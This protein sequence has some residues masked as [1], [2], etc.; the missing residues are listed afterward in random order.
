MNAEVIESKVETLELIEKPIRAKFELDENVI[1]AMNQRVDSLV[2]ADKQSR[3]LAW[4]ERQAFRK[5]RL[6]V[7]KRQEELTEDAKAQIKQVKEVATVLLGLL[8]PGE[9]AIVGKIAAYDAKVES[10][11]KAAEAARIAEVERR[12][13]SFGDLEYS[14][15]PYKVERMSDAEFCDELEKASV[16]FRDVLAA[17]VEA[18]AKAEADRL[19]A[20]EDEA[21]RA[22]AMRIEREQLAAERK[23]LEAEKAER[24][25]ANRIAA[26]AMNKEREA[27]KAERDRIAKAD[28]ERQEKLQA[29]ADEKQRIENAAKEE[30][31]RVK[32]EAENAKRLEALKPDIEKIRAFGDVLRLLELPACDTAKG[33]AF[34]GSLLLELTKMAIACEEFQ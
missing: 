4:A 27:L 20:I 34:A 8:T 13:K 15:S 22:E 33:I 32:L 24:D 21:A 5:L 11:K 17:R 6:A 1:V 25:E 9:D 19:K 12:L 29:E 14:I 31:N 7:T 18:K 10:A 3:E 23:K 16:K 26:E 2:V 30:A 28:F